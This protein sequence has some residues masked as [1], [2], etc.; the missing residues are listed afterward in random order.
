MAL[1]Y[2]VVA[3][4]GVVF[5][6]FAEEMSRGDPDMNSPAE[7]RF[8]GGLILF[9]CAPLFLMYAG[10]PFLPRRRWA[11]I[12]GIVQIALGLTSICTMAAAVPL[13][14]FWVKPATKA[15]FNADQSKYA[16]PPPPGTYPPGSYPPGSYPPPSSPPPK[17]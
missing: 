7:A 13:L 16:Y 8:T 3:G 5:V 2:L 9:F 6:A 1:L 12:V 14:I 4:L 10:G 17:W 11:W 15:F